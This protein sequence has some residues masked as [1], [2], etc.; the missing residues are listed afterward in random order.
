MGYSLEVG[1]QQDC[2]LD[3]GIDIRSISH[4]HA[5]ADDQ[6]AFQKSIHFGTIRKY[7][8][9]STIYYWSYFAGICCLRIG[10]SMQKVAI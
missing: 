6:F 10:G 2:Q 8:K 5:S 9:D 4:S 3:G 1:L 7:S